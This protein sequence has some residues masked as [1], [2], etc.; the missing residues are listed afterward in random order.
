MMKSIS[1]IVCLIIL[2][3]TGICTGQRV[4]I[5][6]LDLDP[7]GV[8]VEDSRFLSDRLRTELFETG[9]FQVIEREKMEEIL[10]EQGF[11]NTG[12]TSVECAVEIGQL[13]NVNR[14]VAGALGKIEDIYSISLRM[15]D[16]QTGAIVKTATEDYE[17][18]LSE[19]LTD[20]IPEVAG[21]LA[22]EQNQERSDMKIAEIP[23]TEDNK[24]RYSLYLKYGIAIL[25]YTSELND[26]IKI[27][28]EETEIDLPDFTNHNNFSLEGQYYLSED[29]QV[30]LGLVV[31]T[32]YSGWQIDFNIL[33][34]KYE[35]INIERTYRFINWYI[36]ANYNF[37]RP[38]ENY[39]WYVGYDV[40]ITGLESFVKQSYTTT[41][42]D[43][44]NQEDTYTYTKFSL[45]LDIGI[46]YQL[47]E[48]FVL[49]GEIGTQILS[50][51]DTS[52]E[53][54]S[55]D[56]PEDLDEVVFPEK[57]NASGMRMVLFLGEYYFKITINQ[58]F[59]CHG[60][61]PMKH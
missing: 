19:V 44:V 22:E 28:R 42:G 53:Q 61:T 45:K 56:F 1:Y 36:G 2:L 10:N 55:E 23:E 43:P 16:V 35:N 4:N 49:G 33:P 24:S 48:S 34:D 58:T 12:C 31:Q 46:E 51:Y 57:I 17:G 14:I 37:W 5:A 39:R 13:L 27:F 52:N 47:S 60:L 18:K 25:A 26:Q 29:W 40:G 3:I 8:S 6:V 20:V 54:V 11:Q 38:S 41:S 30:K 59:Y 50:E 32:L 9:S 15:I 21:R 7:T